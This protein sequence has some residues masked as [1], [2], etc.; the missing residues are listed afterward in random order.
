LS[1]AIAHTDSYCDIYTYGDSNGYLY[2]YSH[3]DVYPDPNRYLYSDSDSNG[4]SYSYGHRN[5]NT[6]TYADTN[7]NCMRCSG[8]REWSKSDIVWDRGSVHDLQSDS[9]R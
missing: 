1:D 4:D 9:C 5:V 7:C 3:S 6:Y 2:A 8:Y